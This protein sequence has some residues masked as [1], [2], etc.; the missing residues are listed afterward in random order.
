MESSIITGLS[1]EPNALLPGILK[2][3]RRSPSLLYQL[4]PN[5]SLREKCLT[6]VLE[7]NASIQEFVLDNPLNSGIICGGIRDLDWISLFAIAVNEENADGGRVVTAPT[8]GAAGVIPST[9]KY[10]LE[11]GRPRPFSKD[12]SEAAILDFLWTASAIGTLFKGGASLSAAEVGCQGE[13]GVAS[14]MA[15]GGLAALLGGTP[16]HVLNAAEIAME[17]HLGSNWIY[18][19]YTSDV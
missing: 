5:P 11:F 6:P 1:S 15:A 9:L 16:S 12:Y 19:I 3:K 14:A 13:I 10:W 2:V 4:L 7:R 8:N 18:L 17:H